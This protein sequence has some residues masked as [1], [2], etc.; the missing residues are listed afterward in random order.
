MALTR[1]VEHLHV[2]ASRGEAGSRRPPRDWF[3]SVD[4]ALAANLH[5]ADAVRRTLLSGIGH[6]AL[7]EDARVYRLLRS[8]IQAGG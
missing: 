2:A 3:V 6:F 5:P 1:H 4:S 7:L 8:F